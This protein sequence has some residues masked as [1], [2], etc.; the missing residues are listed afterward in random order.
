V[1]SLQDIID[2]CALTR[3]EIRAIARHEQISEISA[4][5]LG[6]SLLQSVKGIREIE[7]FIREDMENAIS[8]GQVDMGKD[9]AQVL[10][11]FKDT[12]CCLEPAFGKAA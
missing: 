12:H 8:R 9:F 7:R 11:Q 5:S 6:Q 3:G 10:A 1:L 2:F 4:A